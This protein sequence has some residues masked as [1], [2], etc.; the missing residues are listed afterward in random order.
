MVFLHETLKRPK[1]E[2]MVRLLLPALCIVACLWVGNPAAAQQFTPEQRQEIELI[3]RDYLLENPEVLRDALTV[4]QQ[5]ES[6]AEEE[7]QRLAVSERLDDLHDS[8]TSPAMGNLQGDVT[9][10]EF[11]DYQCGYC[12]TIADHVFDIVEADSNVKVVLKEIP[13]LGPAS[14]TAARAALA[15][16]EQGKYIELH[17]ALMSHRG[18][19]SDRTIFEIAGDVGLDVGKLRTDMDDQAIT[20]EINANLELAQAIGVRGTPAFVVDDVVVPG[21]VPL[22]SLIDLVNAARES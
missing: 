17:S 18:Q 2:N 12:K 8:P 10:V 4:L 3:L 1:V 22:E 21:A 9:V 14:T 7:R 16:R 6:A 20:E 11:F 15:A 13:I 19:L 5:R